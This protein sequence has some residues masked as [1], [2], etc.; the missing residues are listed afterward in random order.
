MID[1]IIK[2]AP[3]ILS[4]VTITMTAMAGRLHRKSWVVGLAGN[5]LWLI[6]I[7]ASKSWGFL[8]LNIVL[9]FLY[10]KNHLSWREKKTHCVQDGESVWI[11]YTNYRGEREWRKV[12]PIRVIFD[13]NEWHPVKQWLLTAQDVEKQE[14][15]TF[16]F[17]GI[18]AVSTETP[19]ANGTIH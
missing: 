6:W 14:M 11:D 1:L 19:V 17:S 4:I 18:H 3:W 16:A 12:R 9:F 2:W 7:I 10:A 15:R 13:S 5:V 8:P